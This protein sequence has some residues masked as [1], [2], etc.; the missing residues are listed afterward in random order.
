MT[1]AGGTRVAT[2]IGPPPDRWSGRGGSGRARVQRRARRRGVD[3]VVLERGRIGQSWRDQRWDSLRLNNPGWMNPM[4][5]EQ[6]PRHLPHRRRGRRAPGQA[7]RRLPGARGRPGGPADARPAA[8]GSCS[9]DDGE[10]RARTVVVASGGENVPRSQA[11]PGTARP[12]RAVPRRGLPQPR[13]AAR[14]CRPGRRQRAVRLRRSR[15]TCSARAGGSSWRP[16]RSAAPRR[17]TAGG[18]PWNGWSSAASS[19]SGQRT[20]S[21]RR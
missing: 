19:S 16:A 9:P 4:L 7:R 1:R 13:P 8:C 6:P 10:L 11:R 18:T 21:T 12:G 5:G 17:A 3:H 2:M 14:R 20:W 15:R